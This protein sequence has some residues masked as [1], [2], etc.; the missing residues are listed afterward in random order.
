MADTDTPRSSAS[1]LP[2][3]TASSAFADSPM[4]PHNPWSSGNTPMLANAPLSTHATSTGTGMGAGHSPSSRATHHRCTSPRRHNATERRSLENISYPSSGGTVAS[5]ASAREPAPPNTMVSVVW[6]SHGPHA[7]PHDMMDPFADPQHQQHQKQQTLAGGAK[8]NAS[9]QSIASGVSG[10]VTP[11]DSARGGSSSAESHSPPPPA[12]LPSHE[13]QHRQQQAS[14][15]NLAVLSAPIGLEEDYSWLADMPSTIIKIAPE[16]GGTIFKHVNYHVSRLLWLHDHLTRRFPFRLVVN[17][18]PKKV[19]GTYADS[20]FLERRRRALQRYTTHIVRHPILSADPVVKM[21]FSLQD[22]IATYRKLHSIDSSPEAPTDTSGADGSD[23]PSSPA[24]STSATTKQIDEYL[25]HLSTQLE[26][27]FHRYQRMVDGLER[28]ASKQKEMGKDLMDVATVMHEMGTHR[29]HCFSSACTSCARIMDHAGHVAMRMEGLADAHDSHS[30]TTQQGS[31][32]SLKL[33]RDQCAALELLLQRTVKAMATHQGNISA[34][35]RKI[36]AT[37]NASGVTWR[38][39]RPNGR[40]VARNAV[41]YVTRCLD[42]ELRTWHRQGTMYALG[43][44]QWVKELGVGVAGV[45]E[46]VRSTGYLGVGRGKRG[47]S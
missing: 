44:Q 19:N 23:L 24:T 29:P 47:G 37:G 5:R 11:H 46:V 31:I 41:R 15:S 32:E 13:R 1:D 16:K 8:D 22:D 14:A 35:A 21:F 42:E 2:S 34:L 28:V 33:L 18:P 27:L 4:D 40:W 45:E 3:A 39:A 12:P 9:A 17:M 38:S 26:P 20:V 7:L 10:G 25:T 43:V 30:E 36:T 6:E